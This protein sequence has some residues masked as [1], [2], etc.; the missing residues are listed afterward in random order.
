MRN[1]LRSL[2]DKTIRV[3]RASDSQSLVGR[4]NRS[5]EKPEV[6]TI[7]SD[8]DRA[9]EEGDDNDAVV[10]SNSLAENDRGTSPNTQE[11]S[12]TS[13]RGV[14]CLESH[15]EKEQD[16]A[17]EDADDCLSEKALGIPFGDFF[18]YYCLGILPDGKDRCDKMPPLSRARAVRL[19]EM[20]NDPR[21]ERPY[22]CRR[23]GQSEKVRE[24]VLEKNS[25]NKALEDPDYNGWRTEGSYLG[26]NEEEA[27]DL[28][29]FFEQGRMWRY[30]VDGKSGRLEREFR[31]PT[32]MEHRSVC[33][34]VAKHLSL[35]G[36]SSACSGYAD[37]PMVVHPVPPGRGDPV[38]ER[39]AEPEELER[40][41]EW[42]PRRRRAEV[43][44]KD[45][46][47]GPRMS[48]CVQANPGKRKKAG[49][50]EEA[51]SALKRPRIEA[52]AA[53]AAAPT[54]TTW[55]TGTRASASEEEAEER[56]AW[57][58][59]GAFPNYAA[60]TEGLTTVYDSRMSGMATAADGVQEDAAA[61]R[62]TTSKV[63][64]AESEV[65][66]YTTCKRSLI[67]SRRAYY[68]M[69]FEL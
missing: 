57:E 40:L 27:A 51:P 58:R 53:A 37:P 10:I 4:R 9:E 13:P 49:K 36:V 2:P 66:R 56:K 69:R 19:E 14:R 6:I 3:V 43:A 23:R 55:S 44:V 8:D 25:F 18:D 45:S 54:R 46:G 65:T 30:R 35:R 38:W 34:E 21:A 47:G 28:S 67:K 64:A 11:V 42:H 39:E 52:A 5:E 63:G 60:L 29:D 41:P 24:G 33:Q 17:E 50:E 48:T 62:P 1:L 68:R 16:V 20:W 15:Q 31:Y 26:V 12:E 7:E 61:G 32:G 59:W 22:R